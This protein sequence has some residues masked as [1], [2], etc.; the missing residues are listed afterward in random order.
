VLSRAVGLANRGNL[1][2]AR[3]LYRGE[4]ATAVQDVQAQL[5]RARAAQAAAQHAVDDLVG[6]PP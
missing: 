6:T 3:D 5:A 1:A 4:A 2:A